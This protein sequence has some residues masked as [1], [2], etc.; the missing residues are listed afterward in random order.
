MQL[1]AFTVPLLLIL[2]LGIGW[3]A[4]S[5]STQRLRTLPA[6]GWTL[7]A[8]ESGRALLAP[9]PRLHPKLDGKSAE[10]PAQV[11]V[12]APGVS[13]TL[14]PAR[15]RGLFAPGR[16]SRPQMWSTQFAGRKILFNPTGNGPAL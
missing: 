1:K 3:S 16:D 11:L 10:P 13:P 2:A 6:G 7:V 8:R 4:Q 14:A 9:K 12:I 5:P 15:A